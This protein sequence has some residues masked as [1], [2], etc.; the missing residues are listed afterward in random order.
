MQAALPRVDVFAPIHN[1][2][3]LEKLV[4]RLVL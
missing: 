3:S 2:E 4:A 1:L